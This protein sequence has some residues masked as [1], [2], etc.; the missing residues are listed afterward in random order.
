MALSPQRGGTFLQPIVN[1]EAI[2]WVLSSGKVVPDW[3]PDLGIYCLQRRALAQLTSHRFVSLCILA[4]CC[5]HMPALGVV[6][7]E[8]TWRPVSKFNRFS[9]TQVEEHAETCSPFGSFCECVKS[10][11]TPLSLSFTVSSI[12]SVS[13][14]GTLT[15]TLQFSSW[16][17]DYFRGD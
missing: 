17:H 15:Q 11:H 1:R 4:F 7:P 12:N 10:R 16:L 9:H 8:M 3:Q 14:S 13:P 5:L 2:L 6:V